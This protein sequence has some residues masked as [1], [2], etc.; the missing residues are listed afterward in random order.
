MQDT[1]AEAEEQ[2]TQEKKPERRVITK[3]VILE[4]GSYGTKQIVLDEGKQNEDD[5]D[6]GMRV[7]N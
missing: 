6:F 2:K 5:P 1:N 4:D 3:T 7:L